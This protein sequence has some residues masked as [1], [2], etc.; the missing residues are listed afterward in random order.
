M[1]AMEDVEDAQRVVATLTIAIR[2][3]EARVM[4]ALQEPDPRLSRAALE[5][6]L[7]FLRKWRTSLGQCV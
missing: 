3:A 5:D 1:T 7:G 4:G 2:H 6:L